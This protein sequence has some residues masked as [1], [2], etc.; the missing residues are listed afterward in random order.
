MAAPRRARHCLPWKGPPR[1]SLPPPS[2]GTCVGRGPRARRDVC[3]T[4]TRLGFPGPASLCSAGTL[5]AGGCVGLNTAPLLP[6]LEEPSP[7]KWVTGDRPRA[8]AAGSRSSVSSLPPTLHLP[9]SPSPLS[10]CLCLSSVTTKHGRRGP[11]VCPCSIRSKMTSNSDSQIPTGYSYLLLAI[12]LLQ[13]APLRRAEEALQQTR[14]ARK[15]LRIGFAGVSILLQD[16]GPHG[17]YFAPTSWCQVGSSSAHGPGQRCGPHDPSRQADR[18]PQAP[19]T[20]G[21]VGQ[22]M[23]GLRSPPGWVRWRIPALFFKKIFF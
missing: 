18:H 11:T 6:R 5:P 21:R 22:G 8:V 7:H 12:C 19:G 16:M 13:R 15:P 2:L 3:L 20:P 10:L 23:L 17:N 4:N 1:T 9:V 14:P